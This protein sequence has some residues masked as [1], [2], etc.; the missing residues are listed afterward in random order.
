VPHRTLDQRVRQG[1]RARRDA[2]RSSA[3]EAIL[4]AAGE[5]LLE[6]GYEAFSLR[7]VAERVGYSATAI[8]RHFADK[9]A[10]TYAVTEEG[11]RLFTAR[12][13]AAGS[14]RTD[15]FE[16]LEAM[17]LAYIEFGLEHPVYYRVMFMERPH[18]LWRR[19]PDRPG[20]R[21][22]NFAVLRAAVEAAIASGRTSETDALAIS[23]ALWAQ[24]HGTVALALSMPHMP[25]RQARAF[26]AI[27]VAALVRGLER[28]ERQ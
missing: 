7:R 24:T 14:G 17:G 19:H 26:G 20:S 11:F 15:P 2:A 9:D 10:L 3:R 1:S 18:L 6:V 16:W 4:Q 21:M 5:L 25:A 27:G 8:Y 23:N 28:G 22:E 13:R 12:L